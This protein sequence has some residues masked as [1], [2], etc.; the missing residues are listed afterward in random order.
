MPGAPLRLR[1]EFVSNPLGVTCAR[2]RLSWWVNDSRPA[3]LQSAYE[4]LA[5]SSK[6]RLA[7][8][9]SDLWFSGRVE[10]NVAAHV[11]YAGADLCSAQRVWWK[12]RTFDSDGLSSPW[13][14]AA[15]FEMGLLEDS[16]WQ[17]HWIAAPMR[18]SRSRAGH[19]VA[20]RRQFVLSEAIVSARIYI[21]ALGS[22]RLEVNGQAPSDAEFTA[23][24]SDYDHQI[25]YQTFDVTALLSTAANAIGILLADGYYAGL[26]PG[27]GR[28][29]Y[30]DRPQ[31]RLRLDVELDGGKRYSLSSD[32]QWHWQPSWVLAAEINGGEHTDARQFIKDW[33][34]PGSDRRHW[35]PVDVLPA[36]PG[37]LHA[38]PYTA[39]A[40]QQVLRPLGPP[41][42]ISS[43]GR[44]SSVYDFGD[45]ILGR[46]QVH[47]SSESSDDVVL[48]YALDEH[49]ESFSEDTYTSAGTASGEIF[50]PLFALHGFRYLRVV[51][52]D[53]VTAVGDVFAL[54]VAQS[55]VTS[56]SF[57][58]DHPS[59][60]ELFE[61]LHNSMNAVALSVPMR[62]IACS[63]RLPDTAYAGTWLP[64]YAQQEHSHALVDKWLADLKQSCQMPADAS[65][66]V[67]AIRGLRGGQVTDEI[68]RFETFSRTLW[69][70]YRYHGDRQVLQQ[71]YNEL[72]VAALSYR[73]QHDQLVRVSVDTRLYGGDYT[74]GLVATCTLHGALRTSGRVAGVLAHLGDYELIDTL[75]EDVRKA[76]RRRYLTHDG[77]LVGDSQSVYVAALYHNMLEDGERELAERRLIE[78]LQDNNYHVDVVPAVLHALLPTLTRAGRLDLAYMVLLQTSSPSWLASV[79][80][81]SRLV[82]QQPGEF[83]I[84]NVGLWEWLVESL[85]GIALHEDYSPDSNGFR[86]VRVRPMPPFGK[87]FSAGSPVQFVEASVHT[88]QGKY[89]VKW[90]VREDCFELELL[91][92]PGCSAW[93]T[94]PDD[95][96]QHVYSGHHR[97]VMDFSAGGDGIPT[98][99]DVAQN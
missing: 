8:D 73:H 53:G 10:S 34:S 85:I 98:L 52:T 7:R 72:R 16:D 89:E 44:T 30:G 69:S 9:E 40:T 15:S 39:F 56:V 4:I 97:F 62:G 50:E 65:P 90:W 71:C 22:Y 31:I 95:I 36:R 3:E 92:P 54:R 79:N 38:Q 77:H 11:E 14:E 45:Q 68:A 1:C 26:L 46:A 94:M 58:C 57:R 29:N 33:S 47:L 35:S 6:Q 66:Y 2:P 91:I 59:L 63:E 74:N 28:G 23:V 13:S 20:L 75:A 64:F 93:V 61:V 83:D 18:G 81:G 25:Y 19:A 5:A 82:G 78:L 80:A 43:Q 87:Q 32:H 41:K 27:M 48:S 17:A 70:M 55:G 42:T 49:F 60:N 76:F 21:A 96:E 51:F 84:A 12:V 88:L 86:S 99:L 67:P 37:I 24:W